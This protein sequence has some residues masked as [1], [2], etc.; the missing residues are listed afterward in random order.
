M[1]ENERSRGGAREK[2][3]L[4]TEDRRDRAVRLSTAAFAAGSF[5]F[6]FLLFGPFELY[7][8][9][10]RYLTFPFSDF[11]PPM[12]LVALGAFALLF[13]VLSL[14]RG[15]L[16]NYAVT[17]VF[18]VTAAGYI[19]R[20][21]LNIDHGALDGH[22]IDWTDFSGQA[23][24]NFIFWLAVPAAVLTLLYFSRK[25]WTH[26]V[27]VLSAVLIAVELIA[28]AAALVASPPKKRPDDVIA[29]DSG[30][31]EL[32]AGNNVVFFLLDRFDNLYAE[33]V[34][35]DYPELMS[36]LDGFT[37]YHNFTGSYTRTMPSV[38]Y[39]LTGVKCDYSI[40]YDEYF[41]KA[42]S[43]ST[44]LSDIRAAGY[45]TRI[46]T[47][48]SYAV[49][50]A[51]NL[52]GLAD[53]YIANKQTTNTGLM[54]RY[55]MNLSAYVYA[56]EFFK[57]YF[58]VYTGDMAEVSTSERPDLSTYKVNDASFWRRWRREGLTVT[59]GKGS[60]TFYHLLASHE[61]Y[62]MDENG[63]EMEKS[64]KLSDLYRQTAGDLLMIF[65]Y[66]EE[67]KAKGLYDSTT[68]IISADHARTG[69]ITE[70]VSQRCPALYIKPAHADASAPMKTSEKPVCQ[71]NLRASIIS[72]FGI[73]PTPYGRTIE[74]IGEDEDV[75]R[76][77]YMQASDE[78]RRHR[79]V[80]FVTYEI[81]G[82]ANDFSNW[83][84]VSREPIK[85][86]YYDAH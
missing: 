37:Y 59:E 51:Y 61:P 11:A 70:L 67:L 86:P 40:P 18:S 27:R 48:G 12:L 36:G 19:Q 14:F 30:L 2:L 24:L 13:A 54:L 83:T 45:G 47:D 3:S 9:S 28:L 63:D 57:P 50:S 84:E 26:T 65:D 42:W 31:F 71:D 73:D 60:F 15:K 82:D 32:P 74:S 62:I 75:V 17:A 20:N 78:E 16:Y 77:F 41:K 49:G 8:G 38:A 25:Y 58:I 29:S 69:T 6:T 7:L 23:A 55:M 68:V 56:P 46:Y 33:K 39:L 35:D 81:R 76:Y 64:Y 80:E 66:I 21:F 79:D 22:A 4:L 5:S 43:E 85:Y 52:Y 10:E 72:Y 34:L 44:F 1:S 53:N